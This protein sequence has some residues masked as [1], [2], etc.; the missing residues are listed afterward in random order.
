MKD[1]SFIS[2]MFE[3]IK[4][5]IS[6]IEKKLEKNHVAPAQPESRVSSEDKGRP[7]TA[8]ELLRL[9]KKTI[10]YSI[11]KE[12][13]KASPQCQDTKNELLES[14]NHLRLTV[15]K[16]KCYRIKSK[17]NTGFS[18]LKLWNISL[19]IASVL[20]LFSALALK[21]EN[22]RLADIDIKFRYIHA[23]HGIDSTGL[24][25]LETIFHVHRDRELIEKIRK[26]IEEYELRAKKE[27]SSNNISNNIESDSSQ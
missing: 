5:K 23:K 1:I 14:V 20:L 22:S 15:E 2:A 26:G 10:I 6:T 3:E 7:I 4:S 24:H 11:Q 9:V 16:L 27:L 12:F 25:N 8:E 17:K 19:I 21:F 13:Q 18:N